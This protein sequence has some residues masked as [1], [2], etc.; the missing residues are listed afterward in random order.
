MK[1]KRPLRGSETGADVR[2]VQ[3]ALNKASRASTPSRPT[4][5]A[6]NGIYD[7]TTQ[8]RMAA[9]RRAHSLNPG[10]HFDQEALDALWP[11]FDAYGRM[12]YR[13]YKPPV[14]EPVLVEPKQG[15]ESLT[16]DLWEPF[17]RGRKLGFSDLGT[18]NPRSRLPSGAPSDHAVYPARAYDLGISPATGYS[19]PKARAY[20][21]DLMGEPQ[22]EYVILGNKI[23]SRTR[24]L[25]SY[26][27][28]DHYGHIHVSGR[29]G[30]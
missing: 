12:R 22:I 25:H 3:R 30:M 19:N 16:K 9:F 20:F 26:G 1:L 10:K 7:A 5:I 29:P 15:F 13:L 17:S 4:I 6:T 27:G 11:Y 28:G 24:G 2:M 21:N 23:W 14:P 18:Y 8:L